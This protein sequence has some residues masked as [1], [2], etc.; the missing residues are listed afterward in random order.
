MSS[1]TQILQRNPACML[2]RPA[3]PSCLWHVAS[4][5]RLPP[6]PCIGADTVAT[7]AGGRAVRI[8]D[9][10]RILP[11]GGDVTEIVYALGAGARVVGVD[12]T[13]QFP[14]QALKQK[15]NV[16]YMRALSS[17]GVIS[18]NAPA[19]ARLRAA[20]ARPRW[21]RRLKTTSVPYVEV[22]DGISA[23]G[24]ARKVRLIAQGDRRRSRRREAWRSGDGRLR[25][26]GRTHS[27]D[28]AAGAGAVRARGAERPRGRRRCQA[29]ARTPS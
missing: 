25:R 6:C 26:A 19:G 28:Q 24:I 29:R 7:D 13:S 23:A 22:P 20:R 15:K 10:S 14:S 17:E 12:A 9:A 5:M 21:S 2:F 16:G 3:P 4:P 1:S 27:E 11:I 8:A 18:V